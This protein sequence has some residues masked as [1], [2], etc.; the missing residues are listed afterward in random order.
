ML[1]GGGNE[2]AK[3][4]FSEPLF[5]HVR[6]RRLEVK[7]ATKKGKSSFELVLYGLVSNPIEDIE[8]EGRVVCDVFTG[9]VKP[10]G[11][12]ATNQVDRIV[13]FL[14][15]FLTEKALKATKESLDDALLE[16]PSS[17]YLKDIKASFVKD[18][19]VLKMKLQ[20]K[21]ESYDGAVV[22][23]S[24]ASVKLVTSDSPKPRA[25]VDISNIKNR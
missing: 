3:L 17:I 7:K 4:M 25:T 2:A 5:L 23:K 6:K 21:G 16:P 15:G 18:Y 1:E 10:L 11:G 20:V 19:L 13:K 22:V 9:K 12:P 24:Y 8:G 14:S